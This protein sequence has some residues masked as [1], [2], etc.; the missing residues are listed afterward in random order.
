MAMVG[1]QAAIAAEPVTCKA[2]VL[3]MWEGS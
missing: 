1:A 3:A 2:H